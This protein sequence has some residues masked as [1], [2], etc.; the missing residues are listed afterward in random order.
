MRR[1]FWWP[2]ILRRW[3]LQTFSVLFTSSV[4]IS[5]RNWEWLFCIHESQLLLIMMNN[6]SYLLQRNFP[7]FGIFSQSLWA[8]KNLVVPGSSDSI[9]TRLWAWIS[10]TRCYTTGC[11]PDFFDSHRVRTDRRDSAAISPIRRSSTG[12]R[13]SST[14]C[15]LLSSERTPRSGETKTKTKRPGTTSGWRIRYLSG[16]NPQRFMNSNIRPYSSIHSQKVF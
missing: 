16:R 15:F 1:R 4:C 3:S 6:I 14:A 5:S 9:V 11:C 12:E 13:S 8:D 2:A 7:H 10:Q